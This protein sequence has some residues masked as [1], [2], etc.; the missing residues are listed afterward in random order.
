MSANGGQ[1]L[2]QL[3]PHIYQELRALAGNY[4]RRER[5]DHTLQPT[6]LVHEA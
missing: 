4:L 1:S 3:L 5:R 6:A 2:S